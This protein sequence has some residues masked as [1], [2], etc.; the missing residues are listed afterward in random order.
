[1]FLLKQIEIV[2]N[3]QPY[4]FQGGWLKAREASWQD[5]CGENRVK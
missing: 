3:K 1:M 5:Y 2:E 4:H